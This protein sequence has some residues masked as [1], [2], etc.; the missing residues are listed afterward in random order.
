MITQERLKELLHYDP[1]TGVFTWIS[2][3]NQN[4]RAGD[5]AGCITRD[6]QTHYRSIGVDGSLY[7]AHRL[8][9]L[10]TQGDLPHHQIDH[11]DG[12]GLNNLMSNLRDV[13]HR[14][15]GKN[16]RLRS[17]NK[18]GVNGVCYHKLSGKWRARIKTQSGYKDLG[19]FDDIKDAIA[20]RQ[21]ADVK[22]GYHDNHGQI[23][24]L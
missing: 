11:I 12:N 19:N 17:N 23:R 24:V 9:W 7:K 13:T 4:V 18:S 14:E 1:D 8:V 10:Y 2:N 15:N 5:E 20:A 6:G 21:I 22:H 3:M 16:A